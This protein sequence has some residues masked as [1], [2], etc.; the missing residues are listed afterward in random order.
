M[1]VTKHFYALYK[2]TWK[3]SY[4]YLENINN[5]ISYLLI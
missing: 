5:V 3:I 4:Y 1:I 2:Y